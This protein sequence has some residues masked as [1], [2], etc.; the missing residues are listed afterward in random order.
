MATCGRWQVFCSLTRLI[1]R[2][3]EMD[4]ATNESFL[5]VA[6]AAA[7]L[8]PLGPA[9]GS[10]QRRSSSP[11]YPPHPHPTPILSVWKRPTELKV[12]HLLFYRSIP[13]AGLAHGPKLLPEAHYIHNLTR[14]F[15]CTPPPRLRRP[16]VPVRL[17]RLPVFSSAGEERSD[18]QTM[19]RQACRQASASAL[20]L[21]Q[22]ANRTE[23][24][25]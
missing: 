12:T 1:Y 11:D 16:P 6:S 3:K 18:R 14:F 8:L 7:G 9:S 4:R 15:L 25:R 5:S 13:A 20:R 2:Q 19:S 21:P 17:C 23:T 10:A 24:S 22:A